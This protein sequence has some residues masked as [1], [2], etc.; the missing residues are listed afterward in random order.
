MDTIPDIM[1]ACCILHN[2][3]IEDE[4]SLGLKNVSPNLHPRGVLFEKGLS[5]E[6]LVIR[7]VELQ[8][9]ETHYDLAEDLIEDLWTLKGHGAPHD[10]SCHTLSKTLRRSLVFIYCK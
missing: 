8:N 1:F 4:S 2:M 3:V 7:T 5:F 9:E 10:V 6:D